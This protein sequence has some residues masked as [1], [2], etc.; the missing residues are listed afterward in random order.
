MVVNCYYFFA[1]CYGL[2]KHVLS[3]KYAE[4]LIHGKQS[5]AAAKNLIRTTSISSWYVIMILPDWLPAQQLV[6]GAGITMRLKQHRLSRGLDPSQL[7]SML[8]MMV[9]KEVP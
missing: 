9:V 3:S 1:S 5:V 4:H 8:L 7:C 6:L 2:D